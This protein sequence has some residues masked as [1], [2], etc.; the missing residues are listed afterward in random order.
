[1]SPWFPV[2]KSLDKMLLP[3]KQLLDILQQVPTEASDSLPCE[4][5]SET[6]SD[7][8]EISTRTEALLD[9]LELVCRTH[10]ASALILGELHEQCHAFL[11]GTEHE[12]D[13]MILA[14]HL[15]NLPLAL[16]LGNEPPECSLSGPNLPFTGKLKRWMNIRLKSF[17]RE[18]THLWYSWLKSKSCA[19]QVSDSIL[20]A[21]YEKHLSTLTKPDPCESGPGADV[22][23]KIRTNKCFNWVLENLRKEI[24]VAYGAA[25]Q[26]APVEN[27][28]KKKKK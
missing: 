5:M 26:A 25:D 8:D 21:S 14:K 7:S 27:N 18:N 2:T 11:D 23:E 10:G 17:N 16:Y 13:W 3:S 9:G 12:V 6:S 1:V 22:F 19:E 20:T 15:L 4:S 28:K 24:T